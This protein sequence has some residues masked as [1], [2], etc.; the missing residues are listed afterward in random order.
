L[1]HVR[2]RPRIGLTTP[3]LLL[4]DDFKN[5]SGRFGTIGVKKDIIVG[6]VEKGFYLMEHGR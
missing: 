5:F 2:T 1:V 4:V 6:P 3:F